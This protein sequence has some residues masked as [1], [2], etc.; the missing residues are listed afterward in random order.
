MEMSERKEQ[1]EP[2]LSVR[3]CVCVCVC[4]LHWLMSAACLQKHLMDFAKTN[5]EA[6]IFNLV[7]TCL[8]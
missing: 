7:E 3:V 6:Y 1:K 8:S 4:P 2:S 5:Y